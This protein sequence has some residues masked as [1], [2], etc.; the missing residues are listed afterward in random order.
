MLMT[1]ELVKQPKR[2]NRGTIQIAIIPSSEEIRYMLE[3]H[4]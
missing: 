1:S 3:F 2:V 4:M